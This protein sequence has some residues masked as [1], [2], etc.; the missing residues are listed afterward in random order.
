MAYSE[1][2]KELMDE[3][4]ID[5]AAIAQILNYGDVIFKKSNTSLDSCKT[6]FIE[7]EHNERDVH[8]T[9]ANCETVARLLKIE[10]K[11]KRP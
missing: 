3:Q 2:I 6:Y 11:K 8:L 1:E 9:I 5:S 4:R 7:G 10:V